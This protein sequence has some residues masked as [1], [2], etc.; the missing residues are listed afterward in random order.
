M[1]STNQLTVNT[2]TG[3][4]DT[5][6]INF[7]TITVAD[8][9]AL[10]KIT[11]ITEYT[12]A[13]SIG[14]TGNNAATYEAAGTAISSDSAIYNEMYTMN[15]EEINA[16][17]ETMNPSTEGVSAG[18]IN[19]S[20][21]S[22]NTVS[23][24]LTVARASVNGNSG[25]STGDESLS[26]NLWVQGFYSDIRQNDKG[27]VSGYDADGYGFVLGIDKKISKYSLIY[28]LAFSAGKSEVKSKNTTTK[29]Q[30]DTDTLQLTLYATKEFRNFYLEGMIS[31]ARNENSGSRHIVVGAIE[32]DAQA[33][34]D[35]NLYAARVGVGFPMKKNGFD[36]VPKASLNYIN[37]DTQKYTE[38]GAGSMN[39]TVDTENLSKATLKAGVNVSRP[40][41]FNHGGTFIPMLRTGLTYEMGDTFNS[42]NSTFTAGGSSFETKGLDADDWSK[43]VGVGLY[44]ISAD[45]LKEFKI[46]Y[47]LSHKS[48]YLEQIGLI[49]AIYRF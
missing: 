30:T 9:E 39:L 11:V 5:D 8:A 2:I 1:T 35:S 23:D 38:T 15:A 40:I 21:Y 25:I 31:Y 24:H 4:N 43:D 17:V 33:Q 22:V 16:A 3:P 18:V 49:T 26:S 28:G 41:V 45:K 19:V 44:Y 10:D 46:D 7:T 47:D 29:A 13:T 12:T 20:N 34:Y 32:R 14:I 36:I 6:L 27:G 48:G 37:L 42:S